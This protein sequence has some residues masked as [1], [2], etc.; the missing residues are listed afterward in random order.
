MEFA[1]DREDQF[2][3]WISLQSSQENGNCSETV[4]EQFII[5]GGR[6]GVGREES[7]QEAS[8]RRKTRTPAKWSW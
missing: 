6:F 4:V 1:W 8:Q 5:R 3:L 7:L 2:V